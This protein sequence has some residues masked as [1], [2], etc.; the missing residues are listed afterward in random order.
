VA[1]ALHAAGATSV[2]AQGL[3]IAGTVGGAVSCELDAPAAESALFAA[4]LDELLAPLADPRWLVSRLVLPAPATAGA[5]R[6]LALARAL[7]RPV[8]AAVA[9]HAVPGAL[10]RTR[11]RVG[12]F[13]SAWRTHVGAGRLV[14]AKDPE[15]A[16]LLQLL[17]GEDP[18][19]LTSRVRTVWR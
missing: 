12:A 2:G 13:E 18:F 14:L 4:S 1:D 5:R 9:W 15:G 11:S 16:A 17:H 10:S 8:E 7:G 19:A 6:K 3:R